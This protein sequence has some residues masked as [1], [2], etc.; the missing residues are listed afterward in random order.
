VHKNHIM[1]MCWVDI[2]ISMSFG[3]QYLLIY[4]YWHPIDNRYNTT[5]FFGINKI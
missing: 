4:I 3:L 5:F 1:S 2:D